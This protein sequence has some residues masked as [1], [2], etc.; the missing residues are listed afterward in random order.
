M[1]KEIDMVTSIRDQ[2]DKIHI[3]LDYVSLFIYLADYVKFVEMAE[4]KMDLSYVSKVNAM[5][6]KLLM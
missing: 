4:G 3:S 2:L 6:R 5:K 1:L